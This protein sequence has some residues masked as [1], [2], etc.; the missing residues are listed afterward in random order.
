MKD[1]GSSEKSIAATEEKQFH[2]IIFL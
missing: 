1:K 2:E